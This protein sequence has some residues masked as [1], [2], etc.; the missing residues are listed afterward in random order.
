MLTMNRCLVCG[1]PQ[2]PWQ[3]V[4]YCDHCHTRD[5]LPDFDDRRWPS[6]CVTAAA[7]ISRRN[8]LHANRLRAIFQNL[9]RFLVAGALAT[10]CK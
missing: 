4:G 8:H 5:L 3:P 1:E 10:A 9:Y 2:Q 7:N 6:Y